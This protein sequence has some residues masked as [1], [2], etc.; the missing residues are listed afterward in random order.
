MTRQRPL[1]RRPDEELSLWRS[2]ASTA[3]LALAV[4]VGSI[5]LGMMGA[6]AGLLQTALLAGSI[7]YAVWVV[8][9]PSSGALAVVALVPLTAGLSRG[10]PVPQ[11]KFSEVVV[12]ATALLI[13]VSSH[14]RATA[15]QPQRS[16]RASTVERAA[17]AYVVISAVLTLGSTLARGS[18]LTLDVA[19]D[20][21]G[22]ALFYVLYR[23]IRAARLTTRERE[24]AL[25]L[26]VVPSIVVVVIALGQNLDV[27]GVRQFVADVTG[28]ELFNNYTY[29]N[30]PVGRRST[31]LFENWHSL[32]GYLLPILFVCTVVAVD[33]GAG[34]RRRLAARGLATVALVGLFLSQSLTVIAVAIP[35]L[36]AITLLKGRTRNSLVA[37]AGFCGIALLVAGPALVARIDQQFGSSND[38][39]LGRNIDDR[40]QIWTD[41]YVAPLSQYWTLGYGSGLPPQINWQHTES[42]YVTLLLRGGVL[43]LAAFFIFFLLIAEHSWRL[44]TSPILVDRVI[45][46]ALLA[47]VPCSL[48]MHLVFPYFTSSGFPHVVW[49]LLALLPGVE[50]A[51]ITP[52]RQA[53]ENDRQLLVS[54]GAG[55]S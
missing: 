19:R 50:P 20:A 16:T 29:V 30:T 27:G 10:V 28:S 37:I 17:L 13:L 38:S 43:L 51:A 15:A 45:A 44:R 22:P 12:I 53:T 39:V 25:A 49:I 24:V 2:Y 5:I 9:K 36:F 41:D 6:A 8:R 31:G 32:A 34:P 14:A 26:L 52:E 11:F 54:D 42:L 35:G 48:L 47:L 40:L 1:A 55:Q 18:A 3:F 23:S 4:L 7:G 21:F 33:E 46:T